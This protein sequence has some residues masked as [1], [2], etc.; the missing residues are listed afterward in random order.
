MAPTPLVETR[1]ET[2]DCGHQRFNLPAVLMWRKGVRSLGS[3][4]RMARRRRRQR[5]QRQ[6]MA[7]RATAGEPPANDHAD[8]GARAVRNFPLG[9][10]E[11]GRWSMF[12]PRSGDRDRD[13]AFLR[14]G[15]PACEWRAPRRLKIPLSVTEQRF[16]GVSGNGKLSSPV[17]V[18]PSPM[19]RVEDPVLRT[20]ATTGRRTDGPTGECRRRFALDDAMR[21]AICRAAPVSSRSKA[22]GASGLAVAEPP[23]PL[24]PR[25]NGGSSR[26]RRVSRQAIAGAVGGGERRAPWSRS[27]RS[28][29]APSGLIAQPRS[30]LI[31][32]LAPDICGASATVES[33]MA[34]GPASA[35]IRTGA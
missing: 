16:R 27:G 8:D 13:R 6:C 15:N 33:S 10:S 20:P 25:G 2:V 21:S 24:F 3:R 7:E 28:C 31:S 32:S 29:L 26:R 35:S 18:S 30:V 4:A 11:A 12:G 23:P 22:R 5:S 1:H 19:I 14:P 9:G 34:L 17:I